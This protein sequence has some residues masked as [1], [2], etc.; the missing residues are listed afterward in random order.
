MI[1][2]MTG[3][4]GWY[5]KKLP[6]H[7]HKISLFGMMFCLLGLAMMFY[8]SLNIGSTMNK[9]PLIVCYFGCIT[10]SLAMGTLS[11]AIEIHGGPTSS[12]FYRIVYIV[13]AIVGFIIPVAFYSGLFEIIEFSKTT[14]DTMLG[15]L[16]FLIV[17]EVGCDI[18]AWILAI[19]RLQSSSHSKDVAAGL[20]AIS[21]NDTSGH[22]RDHTR[23]YLVG[24]LAIEFMLLT[25]TLLYQSEFIALTSIVISMQHFLA[26]GTG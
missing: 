6:V 25:F 20:G 8:E 26:M 22:W 7:L 13:P 10:G 23:N 2:L 11:K 9:L 21:D 24:L 14:V 18:F 19:K 15:L 12:S 16:M 3:I 17:L 5:S 1:I 4:M